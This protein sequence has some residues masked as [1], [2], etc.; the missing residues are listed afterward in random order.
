MD[1]QENKTLEKEIDLIQGCIN[2]MSQNSFVVK[3]WLVTLLAVV[4]ALL[5]ETFDMKILCIIGLVVVFSFWYLDGFFLKMENLFRWKYEWLICNRA[6]SNEGIY[7]LN[8]YNSKMWN[9]NDD[10][11]SKE[12][13]SLIGVML[14]KSLTPFYVPL[15]VILCAFFIDTLNH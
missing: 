2:R 10:G 5:P 1:R 6:L 14:G 3:G 15:I 4:L 7:D 11:S 8:P 9:K 12:A 13:P